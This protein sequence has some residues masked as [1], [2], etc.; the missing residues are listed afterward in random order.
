MSLNLELDQA[1]T[2]LDLRPG[3]ALSEVRTAYR[4]LAR[5]SHPDLNPHAAGNLIN[6]LNQAY[7][8]LQAHLGAAGASGP[9]V[10]S[11][12]GAPGPE[13]CAAPGWRLLGIRRD[14]GGLIYQVEVWGNPRR[15]GLP[16]RRDAA[17]AHCDGRGERTVWGSRVLCPACRGK[18]SITKALE[19]KV[20]LPK[21]WKYGGRYPASALQTG[22][23]PVWLEL[24]APAA[25]E[26]GP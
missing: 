16:Q 3:A 12:P 5:A 10:E 8:V 22:P 2:E 19:V 14:S 26:G 7:Q 25:A 23:Q 17:C 4:R 6:R 15:L 24:L 18:G 20:E 21:G 1:Y 11:L 13:P 9:D